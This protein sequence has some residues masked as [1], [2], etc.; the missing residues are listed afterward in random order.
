YVTATVCNST[1]GQW[2]EV[3]SRNGKYAALKTATTITCDSFPALWIILPLIFII[4]TVVFCILCL[5]VVVGMPL[6]RHYA[7]QKPAAKTKSGSGSLQGPAPA[8]A[9]AA[10]TTTPLAVAS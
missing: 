10:P 9:G 4:I 6:R 7:K 3:N 5:L 2:F 8:G 1:T